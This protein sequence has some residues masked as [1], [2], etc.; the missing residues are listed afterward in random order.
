[1]KT[2]EMQTE[3][4]ALGCDHGGYELK[5]YIKD[6]LAGEGY[7]TEDFGCMT[8]DPVEYP[9]VALRI[10]KAVADSG[11]FKVGILFCGTGIGV[12]IA[13]NKVHGI[14]AALCTDCYSARMAKEHNDANIITLGG[15]TMGKA[16]AWE[17]VRT[18]LNAQF[19][20]GIHQQRVEIL[21]R[22]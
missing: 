9:E 19:Q 6:M 18:Y 10:A 14:R 7:Q 21:T 3:V 8:P 4:I 20:G 11:R 5:E 2:E 1:M 22:L 15:R 12:S 16:L 13:A 17:V